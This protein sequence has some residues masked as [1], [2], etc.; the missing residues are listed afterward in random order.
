DVA[1]LARTTSLNGEVTL[2]AY[3]SA[4]DAPP[5]EF[6]NDLKVLMRSSPSP[7][8]PSRFYLI[9]KIPRLP[10]SKLD[11]RALMA[12]D[13]IHIQ[14]ER[15]NIIGDAA[16]GDRIARMVAQIWQHV[17]GTTVQ[18]P[19]DDFFEVGGDSLKAMTFVMELERALKLELSSTL[20]VEFPKF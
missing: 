14:K 17:L 15:A 19:E 5:A 2:I 1:A 11:V 6:L 20:I 13:Q 7:M 16:T 4:S 9:E 8:R 3:V 12:I 18:H 10:S